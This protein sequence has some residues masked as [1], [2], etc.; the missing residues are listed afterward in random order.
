MV[1]LAE[2][3]SVLPDLIAG[4]ISTRC[5]CPRAANDN[6]IAVPLHSSDADARARRR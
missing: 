1:A 6:E 2:P 4:P 3:D 5:P